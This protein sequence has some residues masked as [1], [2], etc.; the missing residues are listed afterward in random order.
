VAT[1]AC[2]FAR[3]DPNDGSF[4][5]LLEDLSG[6]R[7]GDDLAGCSR[8]QAEAAMVGAARL[9]AFWWGEKWPAAVATL[10]GGRPSPAA[11][12]VTEAMVEKVL[13]EIGP[14]LAP[15]A[16]A[17][18]RR[19]PVFKPAVEAVLARSPQTLLHQDFRLD[20]MFF[21]PSSLGD[22]RLE[23]VLID[24]QLLRPGAGVYDLAW[25][26]TAGMQMEHFSLW[27]DDLLR[28][29]DAW[30]NARG[31][32]AYD[33]DSCLRDFRLALIA[34][35]GRWIGVFFN[36]RRS[37]ERAEAVLRAALLRAA[38]AT[39]GFDAMSIAEAAAAN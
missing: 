15:S 9:H 12:P 25:F 24:W 32:D 27:S 28:L 5:L 10:S 6:L 3:F 19:M 1:P 16:S 13:S 11:P 39:T 33:F 36:L 38:Q 20:N 17:L 29:Y 34:N 35:F 2:Y 7:A 26:M 21:R 23:L 14:D 30:L 37:S 8:A 18:A 4:G 22:S 31:V